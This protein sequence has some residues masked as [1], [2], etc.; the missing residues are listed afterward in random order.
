MN[1]SIFI[2]KPATF[3]KFMVLI[4]IQKYV[5]KD[6]KQQKSNSPAKSGFSLINVLHKLTFVV[7][8]F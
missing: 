6:A 7:S 4:L 8:S 2:N 5:L 3:L 1:N